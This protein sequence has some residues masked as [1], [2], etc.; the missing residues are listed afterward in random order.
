MSVKIIGTT[1]AVEADVD[2]NKNL[3]VTPGLPQHPAATAGGYY[4]VC[5]GPAG[6]VAATLATDTPLFG[7]RLV[8]TSTRKAYITKFIL[9]INVAT[10]GVTAGV[11]GVIGLIRFTTGNPS[12]G[13][14][15]TA[16]KQD[17][18]LAGATDMTVIQD[19][20]SALTMTSV[21]YGNEIAWTRI[22]V[23]INGPM[24]YEWEYQPT[25]P[26]VLV[27]GDGIALR[28]RVACPATQTW[29]FSYTAHW[30]EK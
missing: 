19:L 23:M 25:Y 24:W 13:T 17:E 1:S 30:N 14:A 22:P 27:P 29:C 11:S 2:T 15:R 8:S 5:G 10:I 4:T 20:A 16:N 7:M 18:V 26:T 9:Q 12:G 21:A 3:M 6:I 28:T